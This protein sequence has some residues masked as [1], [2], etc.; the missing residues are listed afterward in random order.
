MSAKTTSPTTDQ[1]K[2]SLFT[3]TRPSRGPQMPD[4]SQAI[5]ARCMIER[6]WAEERGIDVSRMM[7]NV[8]GTGTPAATSPPGPDA[9]QND[10][11]S[12]GS[13]QP[14]TPNTF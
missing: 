8:T 13:P 11:P 12:T 9:T 7:E 5:A 10:D 4:A 14:E 2:Y 1:A 3:T 6:A